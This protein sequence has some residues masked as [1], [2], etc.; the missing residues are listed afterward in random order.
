MPA[1]LPALVS[2]GNKVQAQ[3]SLYTCQ[4]MVHCSNLW[5]GVLEPCILQAEAAAGQAAATAAQVA[6]V[7]QASRSGAPARGES[8]K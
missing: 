2:A 5:V 8:V 6:L 1:L 3:V 4:P 7:R